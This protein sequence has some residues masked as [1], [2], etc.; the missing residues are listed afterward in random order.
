[1]HRLEYLPED[2]V[3]GGISHSIDADFTGV[4]VKKCGKR[5]ATAL[6]NAGYT[7]PNQDWPRF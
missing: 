6:G 7:S 4:L 1:M 5:G 2:K 3:L